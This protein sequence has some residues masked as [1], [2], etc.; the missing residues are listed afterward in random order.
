M[1]CNS[2][3]LL[4]FP[5]HQPKKKKKEKKDKNAKDKKADNDEDSRKQ[6]CSPTISEISY[7]APSNSLFCFF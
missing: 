7:Y 2:A 1:Q 5:F 4:I 3:L 6:V